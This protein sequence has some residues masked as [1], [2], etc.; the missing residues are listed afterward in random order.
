MTQDQNLGEVKRRCRKCGAVKPLTEFYAPPSW[1][2]SDTVCKKCLRESNRKYDREHPD[3]HRR[4]VYK[5]ER[6]HPEVVRAHGAVQRALKSGELVRQP[7]EVCGNPDSEAH[8]DDYEKPL[9]VQWLCRLHHREADKVRRTRLGVHLSGRPR[10]QF[11]QSLVFRHRRDGRTWHEVAECLKSKGCS[12]SA[13]TLR[14]YMQSYAPTPE[15]LAYEPQPVPRPPKPQAI[16]EQNDSPKIDP[17]WG[18]FFKRGFN[19]FC[20]GA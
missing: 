14:R 1:G 19:G 3:R 9:E 18:D 11:D 6:S 17:V 8:H 15:D 16:V 5:Y 10:V 13:G 2:R 4:R 7:C 12:I 20:A